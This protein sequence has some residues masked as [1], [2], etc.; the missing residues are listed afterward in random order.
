[1]QPDISLVIASY[2]GGEEIERTL[3]QV[4]EYFERQA[5]P[6]EILV[7]DDGSTDRS[8][9]ILEAVARRYPELV[10]L[11]N[12]R[13]H[14]KGHAVKRGILEAAGRFVCY[15]DVDLAYPIEGIAAFLGPLRAG[16]HEVAVGS[17][18]HADSRFH[19]HPR[20]FRYVY[21]RH[22]LSR[23]FNWS[24]RS[25]LGICTMDTQCGFKGFTAEAAKA[26]FAQVRT[27][28]F[29]FD[30]E[31]LLLAQRLGFRIVEIPVTYTH[32]GGGSSVKILQ[33]L[34]HV[35]VDLLR[36][37]L[38]E[39]RGKRGGTSGVLAEMAHKKRRTG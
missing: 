37:Y 11:M 20:H 39:R 16:T 3:R 18:L 22:L 34:G 6:H 32:N 36:I 14:G 23:C 24:V 28:G 33:N 29:A 12:S 15:T 10:V 26:I 17:R 25:L 21:Q 38:T 2:N 4:R 27:S 19:L 5:L 30:V 13:N 1:M 7:V 35:C 9:G 8:A 31:V